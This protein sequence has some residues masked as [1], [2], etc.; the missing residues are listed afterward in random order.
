MM[1]HLMQINMFLMTKPTHDCNFKAD[2]QEV[3][4]ETTCLHHGG[5]REP[6]A[7][8]PILMLFLGFGICSKRVR[9]N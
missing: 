4:V 9:I 6:K 5:S 7:N 1:A 3:P 2:V 8:L